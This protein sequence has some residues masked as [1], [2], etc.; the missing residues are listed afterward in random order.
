MNAQDFNSMVA[1]ADG[2]Y[3]ES[4]FLG[5]TENYISA[6]AIQEGSAGQYYNAACCSALSNDTTHAFAWLR[7][8][9]EK[10]YSN[11]KW[12]K[13]DADLDALKTHSAWQKII[14]SVQANQD[15][16][17]RFFDKKLKTQLENILVK[18]QMLRGVID[19]VEG[20]YGKDSDQ[21]NYFWDLMQREDSLNTIE[22]IDIIEKHGWVGQ[23]IVGG[24]A[25]M[26]IWL[27]IQHAPIEIQEK[28]L[29]LMRESVAK[30]E[31]QGNHLALLE[32]RILMGNGKPQIY[33]SQMIS[34]N[35]TGGYKIYDLF[36]PEF[37]D[38]R[39]AAVGLGPLSEYVS[40]WQIVFDVP[41]REK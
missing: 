39:R 16:N 10:G 2:L 11:T 1:K 13:N 31:S 35:T 4:N 41:Q 40:R 23:S 20:K 29:P 38:Q 34:D 18:D 15:Y 37:V 24:Q 26:A 22:V 36:E 32:D 19:E 7:K 8:A 6:F 3:D 9:I 12:I 28:Y 5:C 27:V 14:E 33:G 30:R 25:N 17:E 21:M